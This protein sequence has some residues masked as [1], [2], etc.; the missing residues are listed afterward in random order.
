M[1]M[2][3]Y[4]RRSLYK[5]SLLSFL[6]AQ[7][8]LHLLTEMY[9][10]IGD[11]LIWAGTR[12]LL[13]S[14]GVG[15]MLLP[16]HEVGNKDRPRSTLL[17]PGNAALT[18]F[19]HEWLPATVIEAAGSF[20]KVIILPSS[21]DLSEPI[22]AECLSQHNVYA[23]AR[24]TRSYRSVK[25]LG[26]AALCLDSAIYFHGF[27]DSPTSTAGPVE[28]SSLLLALREDKESLLP[29]QGLAP[30]PVMNQDIS[31]TKANLDDW[32]DA[33][34]RASTVVTDRLHV[35]VASVLFA[36]RL[37]YLDPDRLKIS[38]YFNYTFRDTFDGLIR[39]CPVEWL[40]ANK[41][42]VKSGAL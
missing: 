24:Q 38:N 37:I 34:T 29:G 14:A 21:F 8:D 26:R 6:G 39:R 3:F 33:I 40:V 5:E 27:N 23:F 15:Y 16:L 1:S 2:D 41:F 18:K 31:L 9:G 11:H 22:V 35:A 28:D 19:W 20:H 7:C 30:N 36:K 12:D 13:E 25:S 4:T 10:N 32:I 42:V 17:I